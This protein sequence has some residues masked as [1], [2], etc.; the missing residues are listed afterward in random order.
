MSM[1]LEI[2]RDPHDIF[3][4]EIAICGDAKLIV[5]GDNDLLSL[6]QF[7]EISLVHSKNFLELYFPDL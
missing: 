7:G 6:E 1:T 4:L 3:I 2:L 5:T